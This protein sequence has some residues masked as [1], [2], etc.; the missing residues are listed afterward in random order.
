MMIDALGMDWKVNGKYFIQM[1]DKP[2]RPDGMDWMEENL[3]GEGRVC[4]RLESVLE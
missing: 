3:D 1:V 2:P 4:C